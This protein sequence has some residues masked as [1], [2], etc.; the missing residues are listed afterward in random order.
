MKIH[1]VVTILCT[2]SLLLGITQHAQATAIADVSA[3]ELSGM[4]MLYAV[5]NDQFDFNDAYTTDNTGSIPVN[6]FSRVGYYVELDSFWVWASMDTFNSDPTKLGV[7]KTGTGIVESGTLVTNLNVESN[8]PNVNQGTGKNGIIEFWDSNYS[9]N[10][11]GLYGSNDSL[12]DWKDTPSSSGAHGSFQVF[13][14]TDSSLTAA[15][16]LFG[17]TANGGSGIGNQPTGHPDWT[18]GPGTGSYQIRN[19]EIWVGT[20]AAIPEPT[21]MLL[22]GF[23]LLSIAGVNRRKQ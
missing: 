4:Q 18:F 9:P 16:T 21:T 11:G 10:G 1:V 20:P 5:D 13:A 3:S 17:I 23:G 19:L 6:S 15:N 2:L 12:F 22:F 14:F 8:H 7:P